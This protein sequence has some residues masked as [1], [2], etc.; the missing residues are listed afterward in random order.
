MSVVAILLVV[1]GSF[2]LAVSAFGLIRFPDFYTRAHVV[3]KS[4]SLGVAMVILGIIAHHRGG[5]STLKLLFLVAFSLVA[6][7]T[8]IHALAR[9]HRLQ[10]V[11]VEPDPDGEASRRGSGGWVETIDPDDSGEPTD[12]AQLAELGGDDIEGLAALADHEQEDD[13]S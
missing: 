11:P 3:A 9:G 4:E 8:A 10:R 2:F 12:P 5:D 1:G 7:P 6:N 13:H